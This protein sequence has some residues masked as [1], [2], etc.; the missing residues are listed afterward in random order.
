MDLTL[1]NLLYGSKKKIKEKE[2]KEVK[3]EALFE[4]YPA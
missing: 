2:I 4:S 3:G 1:I